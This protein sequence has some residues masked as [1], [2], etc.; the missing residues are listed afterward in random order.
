MFFSALY[1]RSETIRDNIFDDFFV[2]KLPIKNFS[3]I[4][5]IFCHY[6]LCLKYNRNI[7]FVMEI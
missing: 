7:F 2:G 6:N 4:K 1:L 3:F 5:I